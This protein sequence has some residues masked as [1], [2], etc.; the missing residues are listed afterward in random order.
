[1]GAVIRAARAVNRA[2]GRSGRVWGDRYHAR[3]LRTPREVRNG[4]VYVLM[5]WKKHLPS[6]NGIDRCS[7]GSSFNGWARPP[8]LG[9]PDSDERVEAPTTWL[10]STGWKRHGLVATNERPRSSVAFDPD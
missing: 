5:N 7:S 4:I 1:M 6:A 3:P 10:L 8:P 2:A 9:P